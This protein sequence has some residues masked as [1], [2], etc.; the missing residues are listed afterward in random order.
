[1]VLILLAV[2]FVGLTFVR[3]GGRN[4]AV[5]DAEAAPGID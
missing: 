3:G 1:M 4:D 5:A 2:G